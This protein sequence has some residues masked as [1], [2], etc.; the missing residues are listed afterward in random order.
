[1]LVLEN[2]GAGPVPDKG[3]TTDHQTGAGLRQRHRQPVVMS[4]HDREP[5]HAAGRRS[6]G[7]RL[8]T[9]VGIRV[10]GAFSSTWSPQPYSV[11]AWNEEDGDGSI[12]P[13]GLPAESDWVLYHPHPSY[14]ATMIFNTYIWE[15]SRRTGGTL[16][17]SALSR[18]TSTRT[19]AS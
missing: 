8:G 1:M 7:P 6:W 13:L 2:F 19:A 10:R 9:R 14:D 15:L 18:S 17:G 12:A 4:L 5:R 16:C 11:E 3:W